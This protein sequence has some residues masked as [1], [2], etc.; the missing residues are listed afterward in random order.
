MRPARSRVRRLLP[1]AILSV[2]LALGWLLSP[3]ALRAQPPRG[4]QRTASEEPPVTLD[5]LAQ[6][7][8]GVSADVPASAHTA[9]ILG[10]HREGSGA[11][12]DTRGRVLTIGY[13]VLEASRVQLTRQDGRTFPARVLGYDEDS[14]LALLQAEGDLDVRPLILGQSGPLRVADAVLVL[15]RDGEDEARSA[16]VASRRPFVAYWEYLLEHAIYT[17]PPVH[18]YAGA[19]LLDRN[20]NLVGIGSLQ[21]KHAASDG[22]PLVGNVFV[23]IDRIKPVLRDLERTGQ[24]GTPPRPWLG[25]TLTEQF[26][27]VLV[28]HVVHGGPAAA[29]GLRPGDIILQV[30][31]RKVGGL[32]HFYRRLWGLG[33][34]GVRVPLELLHGSDMVHVEVDSGNRYAHYHLPLRR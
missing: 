31:G 30:A 18:D 14:G 33:P 23:P 15:T 9:S 5:E 22:V 8:L 4:V 6:A 29:A 2:A 19:A 20:L 34:A 10:T 11:V 3:V 17:V 24:P 12:I 25:V 1:G 26:G 28:M 7:V 21:V 27:R 16:Q 32:A 13:L